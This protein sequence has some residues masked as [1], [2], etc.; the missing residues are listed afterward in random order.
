MQIAIGG[1]PGAGKSTAARLVA[2]KLGYDFYSMGKI[3]RKL[4]KERG[5]TIDEFNSLPEDTDT[6]V[7]EEQKKLGKEGDNFVNEGRLAFYFMPRSVKIYFHCDVNVAASRI[8][9]DQRSSERSY[10]TIAE[11]ALDLQKRMQNDGERYSRHYGIN[12]YDPS[13]FDFVID[14][15]SKGIEEVVEEV[16][17]IVKAKK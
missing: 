13:K 9:S 10:A 4:A 14:T 11:V 8:F 5:L 15:T 2:E 6:M 12:C 1:V 16:L 3:R 7:D 17:R